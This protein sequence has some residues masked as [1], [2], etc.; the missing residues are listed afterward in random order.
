MYNKSELK[1][2]LHLDHNHNTG[3][4]RELLCSDCNTAIGLLKENPVIIQSVVE[5]IAKHSE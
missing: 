2:A 4:V 3:K 1:K 5:Y